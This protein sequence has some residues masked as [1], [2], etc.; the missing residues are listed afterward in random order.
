MS[1]SKDQNKQRKRPQRSGAPTV[2]ARKQETKQEAKQARIRQKSVIENYGAYSRCGRIILL[3]LA[4]R[5]SIVCRS[6]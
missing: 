4:G 2:A 1:R 6:V 5:E 3:F